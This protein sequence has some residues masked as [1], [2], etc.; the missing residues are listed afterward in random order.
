MDHLPPIAFA[1]EIQHAIESGICVVFSAGN[2]QFSIQPQ[3]PGVLA[4]GGVYMTPTLELPWQSG[5][6]RAATRALGIRGG[7]FNWMSAGLRRHV[8]ARPQYLMLPVPPGCQLDEDE[9]KPDS[10]DPQGDGTDPND[11]WALFSGHRRRRFPQ[12]AVR[13][14]RAFLWASIQKLTPKEIVSVPNVHRHRVSPRAPAFR[15]LTTWPLRGR[16]RRP[17]LDW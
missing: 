10:T 1:L 4:A 2:G 3:V 7:S 14:R 5:I 12:L 9:S 13:R 11:G 16:T 17:V 6:T 8:T 15:G